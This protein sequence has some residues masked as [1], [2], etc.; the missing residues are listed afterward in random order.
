MQA[1]PRQLARLIELKAEFQ[2]HAGT[3]YRVDTF[4]HPETGRMCVSFEKGKRPE[5]YKCMWEI[6]DEGYDSK[7][8]AQFLK[9]HIKKQEADAKA[10]D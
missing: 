3:V 2:K 9:G 6:P 1:I 7:G 5:I 10:G 8:I 4:Y